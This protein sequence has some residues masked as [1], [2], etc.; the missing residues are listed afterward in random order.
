M[1]LAAILIVCLVL[2]VVLAMVCAMVAADGPP[3]RAR[4]DLESSVVHDRIVFPEIDMDDPPAAC[5]RSVARHLNRGERGHVH[6]ETE[7]DFSPEGV[8]TRPNLLLVSGGP[9][10]SHLGFHPE[11]SWFAEN[12]ANVV[13]YD[14]RGTGRSS[15][16]TD[17]DGR[18]TVKQMVDDIEGLRAHLGIDQLVL[19][20]WSYG[21]YLTRAYALAHPGRVA[22]M[23]MLASSMDGLSGLEGA[24]FRG[25]LDK[26]ISGKEIA[27][28][29]EIERLDLPAHVKWYNKQINGLWK[30]QKLYKPSSEVLAAAAVHGWKHDTRPGHDFRSEIFADMRTNGAGHDGVKDLDVPVIVV[31]GEHDLTFSAK[32]RR[33]FPGRFKDPVTVVFGNSAHAPFKDEPELFRATMV[34]FLRRIKRG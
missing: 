9:G 33:E 29:D 16:N 14:Q 10:F 32:K 28:I 15:R 30:R 18:Y 8:R 7:G 20:G 6:Y 23:V 17:E 34:Q 3:D 21:G 1:Q 26:Y 4:N 27:R 5:V 2:F 22:G 24:E 19:V 12:G 25:D 31:E 11:F 13:Y